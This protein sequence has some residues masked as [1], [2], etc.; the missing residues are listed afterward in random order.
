MTSAQSDKR[1][2]SIWRR[3][4]TANM[5]ITPEQLRQRAAQFQSHIRRRNV[6]DYACAAFVALGFGSNI[7]LSNGLLTKLGSAMMML[8]GLYFIY[9]LHR[10]GHAD[11]LPAESSAQSC[12]SF[13]RQQLTRQRDLA[14]SRPWGVA[15]AAPGVVLFVLGIQFAGKHPDNW[16]MSIAAIGLF[17][18][19]CIAVVLDGHLIADGLQREIDS[20]E[21]MD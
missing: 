18:F 11:S 1:P 20:L 8:W 6:R 9:G 5:T 17:A 7:F 21:P 16:E 14:A 13:H 2:A 4:A 19:T 3:Q 10:F 15:L 12:R